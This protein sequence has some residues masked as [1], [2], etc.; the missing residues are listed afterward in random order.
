MDRMK[1]LFKYV[2][3][4]VVVYVISNILIWGLLK[5]SYRDIKEY[6]ID[7]PIAKITI[8]EAKASSRNGYIKGEI[9]NITDQTIQNKYIKIDLYSKR[10]VHL[11]TRYIKIEN[12]LAY[13]IYKFEVNFDIGNVQKFNMTV[14]EQMEQEELNITDLIINSIPI[15]NTL[16]YPN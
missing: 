8:D 1:T 12:M 3:A 11:G 7:V 14:T 2:L 10:D 16:E 13:E 5:V 4:V 9:N 15:T 6:T